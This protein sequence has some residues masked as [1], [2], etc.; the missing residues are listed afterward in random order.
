MLKI[1]ET[2]LGNVTFYSH[3]TDFKIVFVDI[4]PERDNVLRKRIY[5]IRNYGLSKWVVMKCPCGCDEILTLSLMKNFKPNWK[6]KIDK[7]KRI[8]ISPSIWKQDGCKSHFF[9][10]NGRLKWTHSRTQYR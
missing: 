6:I 3:N 1:I 7:K 9:I 2:L 4:Q 8:T 10:I 5:I